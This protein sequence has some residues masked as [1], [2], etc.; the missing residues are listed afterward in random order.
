M[1]YASQLFIILVSGLITTLSGFLV[2]NFYNKKREQKKRHEM[3]TS[4]IVEVIKKEESSKK[5][6]VTEKLLEKLPSGMSPTEFLATLERAS[7]NFMTNEVP[8]PEIS[9]AVENLINNYHEQALEQA[10]VQFWFSIVAAVIGFGWILYTG[11]NIDTEKII[12]ILKTLPGVVM[13][14]VAFLFFRQAAET[15]QRATELYDRLRKDK[16]IVESVKLVSS[17][18][19][20]KVRS[21]V[22]AQISLHMAGLAPVPIDL[23]KF[24]S[25]DNEH[26]S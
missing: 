26:K 5:A 13:D 22:Q 3:E 10:K 23:T 17:I 21:A 14:A 20:Y 18:E 6:S 1:D 15:R 19:D 12:T 4:E 16:Q 8:K 11:S 24:L 7:L 25:T 2:T 9:G